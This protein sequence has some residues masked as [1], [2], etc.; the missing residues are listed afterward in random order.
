[1]NQ[2]MIIPR[3]SRDKTTFAV[4]EFAG[5]AREQLKEAIQIA[6]TDWIEHSE[7]GRRAYDEASKDFNVGDLANEL[8]EPNL[9]VL[10]ADILQGRCEC[11]GSPTCRSSSTAAAIRPTAGSSTIVWRS[12]REPAEKIMI[13]TVREVEYF[14]L[15]PGN[16]GDSGTWDT[17]FIEIPADTP[18]DQVDAAIREAAAKIEWQ[19]EPP[20]MVGVIRYTEEKLLELAAAPKSSRYCCRSP[21]RGGRRSP[22]VRGRCRRKRRPDRAT[23][24]ATV[25]NEA[26]F[27]R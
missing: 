27:S 26:S 3:V 6:V 7:E 21:T 2:R 8:G 16:S 5:V 10:G 25:C 19:K 13:R 18:D 1:M 11:R 15:W 17:D 14:R 22:I 20:V 9:M 12:T 4:V 23:L 24:P